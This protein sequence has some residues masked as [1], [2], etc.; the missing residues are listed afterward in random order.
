MIVFLSNLLPRKKKVKIRTCITLI[1]R[2]PFTFRLFDFRRIN[3]F[4]EVNDFERKIHEIIVFAIVEFSTGHAIAFL[5]NA[6][7]AVAYKSIN[8]LELF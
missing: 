1:T 7:K 3:L 6:T 5:E 4:Y 2:G 8:Q